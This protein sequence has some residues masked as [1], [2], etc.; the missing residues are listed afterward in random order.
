MNIFTKIYSLYIFL[1]VFIPALMFR[2]RSKPSSARCP[3]TFIISATL[4]KSAKSNL[5]APIR[6]YLLKNGMILDKISEKSVT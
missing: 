5:L 6:G 3:F 4:Q 2:I 1:P